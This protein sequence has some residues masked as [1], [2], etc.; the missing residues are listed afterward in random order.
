[1]ASTP[2]GKVKTAVKKMLKVRAAYYTMPV[3][4][5][6]GQSGAADILALYRGVFLAIETKADAKGKPTA[7][8]SRAARQVY[9][10][11]GVPL[12]IHKDNLD[13]LQNVLDNIESSDILS[14]DASH[15][16]HWPH[17]WSGRDYTI[18]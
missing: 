3:T 9:E 5:G 1:M 8:Q 17:D 12:L 11:G 15:L 13:I 14:V 16:T 4:H 7:L 2:E 6:M 10:N 18:D